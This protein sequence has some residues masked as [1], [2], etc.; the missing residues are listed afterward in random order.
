M[1][2]QTS[3]ASPSKSRVDT[4]GKIVRSAAELFY[5]GGY[6][7][8]SL[9]MV[10]RKAEVNRGSLYYFFKSKKNLALAVIDYFERLLYLNFLEPALGGE[11]SGREKLALLADLY[12]KMPSTSSPC[13]GCPIGKLTLELSGI[14]EDLRLRSKEVWI[15]VIDRIEVAVQQAVEEE[16]LEPASDASGHSRA[17]F[18]QI[19]G[20]HI[21]ARSTLDEEILRQDCR[22]AF[23]SLP[24]AT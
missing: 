14:D 23:E 16:L 19:Q 3:S 9:D 1:A 8:T 21:I 2:V 4:R 11:G 24:W 15:G 18:E 13:C 6:Q 7:G 10:A 22:R 17:F 12:S 20:A 5:L